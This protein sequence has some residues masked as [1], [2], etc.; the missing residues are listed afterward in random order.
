MDGDVGFVTGLCV[1]RMWMGE[2]E[3]TSN[4]GAIPALKCAGRRW[5]TLS[6]AFAN[7]WAMIGE[8]I[9]AGELVSGQ[10]LAPLGNG[11]LR[12]VA[13]V[14]ATGGLFR[15]DQLVAALARSAFG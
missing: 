4:R 10:P 13:S 3:R 11:G 9:P 7:V 1:G 8:P 15:V 2:P 6:E 14:P 5:R 12:I